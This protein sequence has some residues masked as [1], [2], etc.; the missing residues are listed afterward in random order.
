ML[1]FRSEVFWYFIKLEKL[2]VPGNQ[3][4]RREG[5]GTQQSMPGQK[6]AI[7][8]RGRWNEEDGGRR[9]R[10]VSPPSSSSAFPFSFFFFLVPMGP[11]RQGGDPMEYEQ[12]EEGEITFSPSLSYLFFRRCRQ[13]QRN[14]QT[15]FL[16]ASRQ[17][18]ATTKYIDK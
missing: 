8:G 17:S 16:K 13:E 2:R 14:N 4:A 6:T 10:K 3:P 18:N 9:E 5:G 12:R 15:I 1:T 7:K 11:V